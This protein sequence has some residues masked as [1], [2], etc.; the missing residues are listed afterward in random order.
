MCGSSHQLYSKDFGNFPAKN[1][2]GVG[3]NKVAGNNLPDL[4]KIYTMTRVSWK[5]VAV[6]IA[7]LIISYY[8]DVFNKGEAK[9]L[10][11]NKK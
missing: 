7:W 3:F 1:L 11:L 8:R 10:K 5:F 4:L 6:V 9:I 2:C